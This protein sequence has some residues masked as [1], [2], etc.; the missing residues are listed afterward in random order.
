VQC[1]SRGGA[2]AKAAELARKPGNTGAV[3]FSRTGEPE[4]GDFEEA[5]IL[6]A[7]GIVPDDF[8][9]VHQPEA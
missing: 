1:Q 4:L 3:A 7:I 9:G 6:R 2:I 8:S 5:E